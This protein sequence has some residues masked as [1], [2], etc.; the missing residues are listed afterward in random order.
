MIF[1]KKSYGESYL[2]STNGLSRSLVIYKIM[3]KHI[4]IPQLGYYGVNKKS[5]SFQKIFF[6][7]KLKKKIIF[8]PKT[9]Y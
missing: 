4:L 5:Y 1:I 2:G 7:K 3:K 9:G 6:H 8:D